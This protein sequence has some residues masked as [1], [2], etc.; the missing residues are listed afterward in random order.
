MRVGE[1]AAGL[2]AL[3][4]SAGVDGDEERRVICSRRRREGD[5]EGAAWEAEGPAVL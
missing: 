5:V 3:L 1:E 4:G 2:L